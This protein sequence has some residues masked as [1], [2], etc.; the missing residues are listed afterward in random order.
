[1]LA[2]LLLVLSVAPMAPEE[3]G[4]RL[5][6]VEKWAKAQRKPQLSS[7]DARALTG[8]VELPPLPPPDPPVP[9]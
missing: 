2:A 6:A 7:K 4:E 9:Q 1:M 3:S 8:C 5:A